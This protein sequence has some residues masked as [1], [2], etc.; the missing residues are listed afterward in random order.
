MGEPAPYVSA[1]GV[2]DYFR[3]LAEIWES[4]EFVPEDIRDLG[5]RGFHTL[6]ARA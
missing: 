5:D 1:A 2:R 6:I 4:V 3:D